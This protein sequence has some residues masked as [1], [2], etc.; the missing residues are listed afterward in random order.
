MN[1]IFES[2]SNWLLSVRVDNNNN[3]NNDDG[4][5]KYFRFLYGTSY[6]QTN[7]DEVKPAI[8]LNKI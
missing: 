8:V 6:H 3:N 5:G 2:G 4:N 1:Y 7:S